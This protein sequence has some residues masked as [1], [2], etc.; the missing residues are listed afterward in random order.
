MNSLHTD[1]SHLTCARDDGIVV[2]M[3]TFEYLD[4]D[5]TNNRREL[6][7]GVLREPPAPFFSH[8]AI[9]LRVARI[10]CE[11]VES[12]GLG[13]VAISPLDVILDLEK[14][15]VVQPDVMFISNERRP[16]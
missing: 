11:H 9:V 16:I 10:L 4:T 8:Q 12:L 1:I 3:T 15:L 6:A 13:Q 7:Y 2:V 5:E 14:D